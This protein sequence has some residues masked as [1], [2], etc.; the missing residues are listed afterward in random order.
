MN[1]YRKPSELKLT[2]NVAENWKRF[3]QE[4]EIFLTASGLDEKSDKRKVMVMLNVMGSE[5]LEIYNQFRYDEGPDHA[6]DHHVLGIVMNKFEAYCNPIKN[7]T[8]E[9]HVFTH[10][11]QGS[12]ESID[13]YVTELKRL[14]ENCN[15]GT[16]KES[17]IR[18]QVVSGCRDE[19]TKL[20]LLREPDLTLETAMKFCRAAE[21]SKQHKSAMEKGASSVKG[22]SA[23]SNVHGVGL[24]ANQRGR[25]RA[26]SWRGGKRGGAGY[27]GG[28]GK[29]PASSLKTP[30]KALGV[31]GKCTRCGFTFHKTGKCPAL[32]KQCSKCQK[33]GHFQSVCRSKQGNSKDVHYVATQDLFDDEYGSSVNDDGLFVDAISS[34][35]SREMWTV[36]CDIRGKQQTFKIDTGAEVNCIPK[37]LCTEFGITHLEPTSTKLLGYFGQRRHPAG[38]VTLDIRYR[39]RCYPTVFQVIDGVVPVKPVLGLSSCLDMKLIERVYTLSGDPNDPNHILDEYDDVF[40]GLGCLDTTY[41]IKIDPKVTPVVHPP[42]RVPHALRDRLKAQ[43][44]KMM[45]EGVIEPV[46]EPSEWVNSMVVIEKPSGALRVCIDPKDLNRAIL[47]EHYPMKSLEDVLGKLSEAKYFSTL[48]AGQAYYQVPVTEESSKLLTF[49]TPFGRYRFKRMAFGI[50]SAPEVWQRIASQMFDDLEGVEVIMDDILIWGRTLDE[51]NE[52]LRR[53]LERC[54]EHHLTLNREKCKIGVDSVTYMGH[55]L[56]R[57]GLRVTDTRIRAVTDMDDPRDKTE[58]KRFLG[59]VNFVG[60]FIP[61]LSQ[62][63]EPLRELLKND[64]VWHWNERHQSCI[65]DLKSALT[66]APVLSY[67]DTAKNV[68]LSVDASLQGLGACVLQSER[69]VAYASRSLNPAEKNYA[70]IEREM[71]AIAWGC[72]KFHEYIYGK[73]VIVESDHKPLEAIWK[74]PVA[75]APPRIQRWLIRL[76][77]YDIQV[78]YVPGKDMHIADALS[79]AVVGKPEFCDDDDCEISVIGNL[80]VSVERLAEFKRETAKDP[81]LGILMR[82]VSDGWPE[83]RDQ[84]D[85]SVRQYW[86]FR[87]EVSTYGGLLLKTERL[88]V[89]ESMRAAMREKIHSSHLGV[90]KC[91]RRA[92]DVLFWP[93]MSGEIK[94]LVENCRLCL[95]YRNKQSRE[96]LLPHQIP[97]RP[98]EKLGSDIFDIEGTSYVFLVDYFSK[99][100]EYTE[101][102]DDTLSDTV[103]SWMKEQFARH[104]I[105]ETLF[106]DNGPQYSSSNFKKFTQEYN[107]NHDTSSPIFPRSN[108]M[109]ERAVQTLKKILKKCKKEGGDPYIAVAEW[110]NTPLE[111]LGGSP[112]QVL[113]GR[114][115]RTLLPISDERLRPKTVYEGVRE[116][117]EQAQLRQKHYYDRGTRPLTPLKA[118]DTVRL[119]NGKT[120][121]PAIVREQL[122]QPRSYTVEQN[123]RLYRRNRQVLMKTSEPPPIQFQSSLDMPSSQPPPNETRGQTPEPAR[124]P[125][126]AHQPSPSV[127]SPRAQPLLRTSRVSGRV[128]NLPEKF[129]DFEM[130]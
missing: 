79:R 32:D 80:P 49:N 73:T 23:D 11:M 50:K 16:M 42:R 83:R 89:P 22:Q 66:R 33:I 107:F 38:Q 94:E 115:T 124:S 37:S 36:D 114:R 128:V 96:P 7:E 98:W 62:R 31:G 100:V 64:V 130:G 70:N 85:P 5:G 30:D 53:V 75:Q 14:S 103:I 18:D 63:S 15:Y 25:G 57:E 109:A 113:M 87:E 21:T 116:R 99:F 129:K 101:L 61:N 105:P 46:E 112:V 19:E 125:V 127:P 28:R 126:A 110:R 120:W 95:E 119:Y 67:F 118:G 20:R 84:V 82:Y 17:M 97:T 8:Y 91:Q 56:T 13:Q 65:Q 106:S 60:K 35:Y 111:G 52:R 123:G 12:D 69:P 4:F 41:D 34:N 2:G 45:A 3:R 51:H 81:T 121:Q 39:G 6:E 26:G 90:E 58:L 47:R 54:R 24:R 44:R 43:L 48:D 77:K 93:G 88:I 117:L 40:N 122:P 29:P 102:P 27:R 72:Q 78:R 108:G 76:Q 71:L 104:G 10:R 59:M 68:T 86:T 74:K 55:M 9:R 92:R 1:Q